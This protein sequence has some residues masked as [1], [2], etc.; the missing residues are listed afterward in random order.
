MKTSIVIQHQ[1]KDTKDKAMIT[2]VKKAWTESGRKVGEI[3]TL[4]LYVKPEDN[5]VYYVINDTET[6]RVDF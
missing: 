3:K 1:G 2:A 4:T 6:G 5:S